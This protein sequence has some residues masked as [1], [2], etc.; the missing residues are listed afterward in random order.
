M[1]KRWTTFTLCGW[2]RYVLNGHF[3][4]EN[5]C[6]FKQVQLASQSSGY[7][8]NN[9]WA[10]VMF[11]WLLQFHGLCSEFVS[12]DTSVHIKRSLYYMVLHCV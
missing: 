5:I 1:K 7:G 4:L 6:I 8:D 11:L 2:E 9:N 12:W 3:H 10:A